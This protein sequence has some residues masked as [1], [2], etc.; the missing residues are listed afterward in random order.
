MSASAARLGLIYRNEFARTL[1]RPLF[2]VLIAILGLTA[3]GLSSGGMQISSGNSAVGGTK[4][5]ITSEFAN[6]KMF[7]LTIFCFYSFF[8]AILMGMSVM[9]DEEMKIGEILHATPLKPEEYI[10]GKFLAIMTALLVA[11]GAHIVL[12]ILFNHIVPNA[13]AI[14]MRGPFGLLNYLRP[15]LIFG[16]PSLLFIAG[17]SFAI[18][19]RTRKPILVFVLPVAA[20]LVSAFFQVARFCRQ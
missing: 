7:G 6:A 20:I 3:W 18:G 11:M 15:A 13:K 8:A 12:T 4:A 9:Q 1:A 17:T 2:W 19:E 10:R 14:E 5:W 16:L